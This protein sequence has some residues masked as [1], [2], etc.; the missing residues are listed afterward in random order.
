MITFR[1]VEHTQKSGVGTVEILLNGEVAGVIYPFNDKGI[2]IYS[3][4]FQGVEGRAVAR[5]DS[6]EGAAIPVPSFTL[7]FKKPAPYTFEGGRIRW[8]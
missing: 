4:H 7:G 8:L 2:R 6:N 3:A 1:L 5:F